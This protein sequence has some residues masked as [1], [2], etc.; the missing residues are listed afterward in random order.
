[1]WQTSLCSC[2]L[3]YCLGDYQMQQP[4]VLL[5]Q[6]AHIWLLTLISLCS[7]T[8]RSVGRKNRECVDFSLVPLDADPSDRCVRP[9][10]PQRS[11]T[12]YDLPTP[13]FDGRCARMSINLC[14]QV[15]SDFIKAIWISLSLTYTHIVAPLLYIHSIA[16]LNFE[17]RNEWE[18]HH[19]RANC[20]DM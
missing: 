8:S 20:E 9:S 18:R 3:S 4:V 16:F 14:S 12:T 10:V 15:E 5:S 13:S 2:Q 6:I 19:H 7:W 11:V 17:D 1:M